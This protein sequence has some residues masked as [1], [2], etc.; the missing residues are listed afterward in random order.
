M[1][2][3][4]HALGAYIGQEKENYSGATRKIEV[5][6]VGLQTLIHRKIIWDTCYSGA[7]SGSLQL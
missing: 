4:L 1:L 6:A 3:K 7:D 2:K 5:F